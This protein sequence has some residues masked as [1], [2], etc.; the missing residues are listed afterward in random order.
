[1]GKMEILPKATLVDQFI[2]GQ[3][4]MDENGCSLILAGKTRA[5]NVKIGDTGHLDHQNGKWMFV[6]ER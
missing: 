2:M 4:Y 3:V 1:M 6:P 5:K